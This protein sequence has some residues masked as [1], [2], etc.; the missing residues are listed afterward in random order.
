MC[1]SDLTLMNLI[2]CLDVPSE[3]KYMLD[4]RDIGAMSDNEL[5]DIR[6]ADDLCARFMEYWTLKESISKKRGVGLRESFKQY[7]ITFQNGTPICD[8]H[9]LYTERAAGFFLAAAE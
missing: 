6:A 4:G 7:E 2:G 3:G 9:I 8:G 1:S 5:A